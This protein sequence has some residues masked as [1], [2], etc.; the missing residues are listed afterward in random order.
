MTIEVGNNSPI[1]L[2]QR[3]QYTNASWLAVDIPITSVETTKA[4][5]TVSSTNVNSGSN[6][7]ATAELL[8]ATTVRLRRTG[9]ASSVGVVDWQVV[10]YN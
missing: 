4:F 10:E 6:Y 7:I 5:V 8:N 3:G 2:I 9:G 1:K